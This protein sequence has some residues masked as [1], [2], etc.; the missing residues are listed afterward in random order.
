MFEY[1]NAFSLWY[2]K[3]ASLTQHFNLNFAQKI[4]F[5]PSEING[6]CVWI[7]E[8]SAWP[9]KEFWLKQTTRWRN[10]QKRAI[11]GWGK[12]NTKKFWQFFYIGLSNTYFGAFKNP[13]FVCLMVHFTPTHSKPQDQFLKYQLVYIGTSIKWSNFPSFFSILILSPNIH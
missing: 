8:V 12:D 7:Y 10:H 5:H 11:V 3:W 1:I 6:R 4:K 13:S 9:T 2:L